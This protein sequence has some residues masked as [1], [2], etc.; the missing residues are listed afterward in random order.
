MSTSEKRAVAAV[1]ER[2][3]AIALVLELASSGAPYF[4]PYGYYDDDAE[5]L[6]ALASRL[7]LTQDRAFDAK[8][9]RVARNLVNHGVL[10]GQM[11]GTLK[12]YY[13]EPTKQMEYGFRNPGKARHLTAPASESLMGPER[14]AAFLLR[15]AYPEGNR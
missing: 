12:E 4:A 15:H 11:R 1:S 14:E 13:G 8:L 2:D 3:F 7:G 6:S 10:Y 9:R 5:F